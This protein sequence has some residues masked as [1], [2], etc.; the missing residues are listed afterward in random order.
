MVSLP[1]CQRCFYRCLAARNLGINTIMQMTD[2]L[3]RID[4]RL[5]VLGLDEAQVSQAAG[6]RDLIR[7][8]RRG[9]KLGRNPSARHDK[10][11]LIAHALD[12]TLA[13]LVATDALSPYRAPAGFHD[14]ATPFDMPKHTNVTTSS[15][16]HI[17]AIFGSSITTPATFRLATSLPAFSLA[18]DDV[19]IVDL[20][21]LPVPGELAVV[22][23]HDDDT[24]SAAH[25]IRRYAP[26]YLLGGLALATEALLRID[27]PSVTVRHPVVASIRGINP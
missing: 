5:A 7:N 4:E 9:V 22:S 6:S 18:A 25:V 24:A 13:D 2:I 19:L 15:Q 27:D 26:P 12:M 3:K 1:Q 10:L 14:T 21:R 8:W 23:I 20:S 16:P 17:T 11:E